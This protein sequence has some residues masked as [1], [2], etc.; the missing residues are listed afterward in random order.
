M[1]ERKD[2]LSLLLGKH[3]EAID[4]QATLDQTQHRYRACSVLQQRRL[5]TGVTIKYSPFLKFRS[6]LKPPLS[7][8]HARKGMIR[9][10]FTNQSQPFL[11]ARRAASTRLRVP[12][13]LIAVE[14]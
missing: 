8:V 13:F 3:L 4:E 5:V 7:H 12:S 9:G 14:R 2:N 11:S 10:T 1:E 6:Q